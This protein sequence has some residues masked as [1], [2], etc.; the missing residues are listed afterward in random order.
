MAKVLNIEAR[1]KFDFDEIDF[2]LLDGIPNETISVAGSV[3][4]LDLIPLVKDYLEKKGKRVLVKKGAYYIGHVLGCNSSAFDLS[5]DEF[6]LLCDGKFHAKNNAIQIQKEIY[7]FNGN[8]LE[9]IT[10][11]EIE[12]HNRKTKGKKTK[13]LSA[14]KV[15]LIVSVKEG[16][17]F[18]GIE[19]IRDKI[20]KLNKK[21]YIFEADNI[22]LNE[23]EN[24]PEIKI[25]V[26]TACF[27]LAR[28]D[29]RIINLVDVLEFLN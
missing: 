16:Q 1:K 25:W 15:G 22:D 19:N 8:S 7:I 10:R 4:Y 17:N 27:G 5:A 11:Q 26:N 13:F 6:L 14:E 24:F 23:F 9:K 28:D 21:V 2:S 3:Q 20:S 18:K 12:E 29:K